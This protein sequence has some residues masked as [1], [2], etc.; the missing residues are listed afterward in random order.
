[1]SS[2]VEAPWRANDGQKQRAPGLILI[3]RERTFRESLRLALG[4]HSEFRV[5]GEADRARDAL[6]IVSGR[7]PDLVVSDFMLPDTDGASLARELRRREIKVPLMILS[8]VSHLTF[9]RDALRAGAVGFALKTESL[10][11][12]IAALGDVL[13]GKQYLSPQLRAASSTDDQG[14]AGLQLLSPREREILC[15]LAAGRS[16]KEIARS[17]FLSP[18]TIDAHRM[19][20]NRKLDVHTPAE[21]ARLVSALGLV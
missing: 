3:E 8:S 2:T 19:H 4:K 7:A 9:V 11:S 5:V 1:M 17:L 16:N 21:L 12:V 18:K 10:L 14:D 20:I 15:F 13:S 6:D